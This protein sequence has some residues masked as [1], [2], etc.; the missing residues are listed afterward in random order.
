MLGVALGLATLMW[1]FNFQPVSSDTTKLVAV[2]DPTANLLDPNSPVWNPDR[3]DP[4]SN[5]VNAD[6]KPSGKTSTTIVPLSSQYILAPQGGSALNLQA[7]AAWNGS[8]MAIR[9]TW[10]DTSKNV[11]GD[12]ADQSKTF[13]DAVAVEFPLE[14]LVPGRTPFRC[15]GQSEAERR[16]NIWQWK[17]ERDPEE[18]STPIRSNPTDK[19]VKNYVGPGAG[20]LIDPAQDDPDS[21]SFYNAQDKTWTVIFKRSLLT[22]NA[23]NSSQFTQSTAG[24]VKAS[25]IAFAVWDGGNGERLSKKAVS[26]WVDLGFQAGDTDAQNISNFTNIGIVAVLTI[27]VMVGAW[28]LLPNTRRPSR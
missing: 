25:Q 20:Y 27:I 7:R 2:Y 1:A 6:G 24:N 16:V 26:T 10:Q 13:S 8:E 3:T 18:T 15:M 11:T 23:G 21:K 4:K 22:G 19:A 12:S 17:A 5:E 28:R 14:E 9:V